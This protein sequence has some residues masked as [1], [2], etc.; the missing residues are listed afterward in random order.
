MKTSNINLLK[1]ITPVNLAEV[2]EKWIESAQKGV[3]ENPQFTYGAVSR[4][5]AE[6]CLLEMDYDYRA[7]D[8]PLK[9]FRE[10]V[11]KK[12]RLE[13]AIV[14]SIDIGDDVWT[15]ELLRDY[16]DGDVSP[17]ILA[18]AKDLAAGKK[19]ELADNAIEPV[20]DKMTADKAKSELLDA[21]QLKELFEEVLGEY[22]I[23]DWK[24]EISPWH[25][26]VTVQAQEG[27]KVFIPK[28][29]VVNR[30]DA[31]ALCGH[32]IET[33][34][35]HNINM[36]DWMKDYMTEDDAI[37]VES[38]LDTPFIEGLAKISDAN[39]NALFGLA[40][41]TPKPWYCIAIDAARRGESFAQIT[42]MLQEYGCTL[43]AA[44]DTVTRVFR[45]CHDTHNYNHY[46][47]TADRMYL[48]GYIES[49]Q[50]KDDDIVVNYAKI[51][52]KNR[53]LVEKSGIVIPTPK[54]LNL[55]VAKRMVKNYH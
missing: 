39:I 28:T 35:R 52:D 54:L 48:Q 18:I 45:G 27:K 22:G 46:A 13:A 29:R 5:E 25:S 42:Q 30:I 11:D 43:N 23:D 20:V 51:S 24:V 49:L 41:G 17:E 47:R 26:S 44:F 33:H 40:G 50:R 32:E 1:A 37:Q 7:T 21:N 36:I 9:L 15:D 19:L 2:K 55:G 10:E 8:S 16:H 4:E 14:I 53:A 38:R 6:K 34:V 12:R 31:I 3:F